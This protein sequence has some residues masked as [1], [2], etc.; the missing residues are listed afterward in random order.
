MQ[1]L[2]H[3]HDASNVQHILCML[4]VDA[5]VVVIACLPSI[6]SITFSAMRFNPQQVTIHDV[7]AWAYV[8]RYLQ[9]STM[10]I[11]LMGPTGAGKCAVRF[12]S[13]NSLR[14]TDQLRSSSNMPMAKPLAMVCNLIQRQFAESTIQ[15]TAILLCL[16]TSLDSMIHIIKYRNSDHDCWLARGSAC[17]FHRMSRID[18]DY[19]IVIRQ[20]YTASLTIVCPGRYWRT[21]F[22]RNVVRSGRSA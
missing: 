15:P 5:P 13:M 8:S 19:E 10:S 7:V 17:L 21:S 18:T 1:I 11:S 9:H 12:L 20:T 6:P 14:D 22:V 16:L 2:V 3:S 4:L